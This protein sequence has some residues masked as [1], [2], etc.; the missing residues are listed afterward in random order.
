M[1]ISKASLTDFTSVRPNTIAFIVI[2]LSKA[3]PFIIMISKKNMC[4]FDDEWDYEREVL[5]HI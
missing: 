1:I 2:L 4:N 3:T 5:I